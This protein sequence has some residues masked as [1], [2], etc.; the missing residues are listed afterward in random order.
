MSGINTLIVS[1]VTLL[2]CEK[3]K[4]WRLLAGGYFGGSDR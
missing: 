1:R 2:K 4:G 3:E